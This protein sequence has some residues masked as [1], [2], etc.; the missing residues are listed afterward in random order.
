M[1]HERTITD[2]IKSTVQGDIEPYYMQPPR[3]EG[4]QM[5]EIY[6]L[7]AYLTDVYLERFLDT[8]KTYPPYG[9]VDD[10]GER[11]NILNSNDPFSTIKSSFYSS[12][13]YEMRRLKGADHVDPK[14]Q[15]ASARLRKL[16]NTSERHSRRGVSVESAEEFIHRGIGTSASVMTGIVESIPTVDKRDA[17]DAEHT[18][19]RYIQIAKNSEQLLVRIA[20]M[21]LTTFTELYLV[22]KRKKD[23]AFSPDSLQLVN[24]PEPKLVLHPQVAHMM[25]AQVSELR[26]PAVHRVDGKSSS[27]HR[28]W[29]WLLT[30][31]PEA[32]KTDQNRKFFGWTV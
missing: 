13:V 20:S 18:I 31:A 12:F 15:V 1:N 16:V 9:L 21:N 8:R 17:P 28:L 32:Y 30:L 11:V 25:P 6:A 7:T 23:K 10:D 22:S 27:V 2:I 14:I 24:A 26:C 3:E 29:E 4:A 19:E 5:R